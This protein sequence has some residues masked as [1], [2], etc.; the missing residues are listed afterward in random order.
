M[1]NSFKTLLTITILASTLAFA[2]CISDGDD[3][4]NT[5]MTAAYVT[6]TGDSIAGYKCFVDGGGVVLL[7]KGN[8]LRKTERAYVTMTY[9]KANLTTVDG[10]PHIKN[11]EV[12][13]GYI[14]P[15]LHPMTTSEATDKGILNP[16]SC[17]KFTAMTS[18]WGYGGYVTF[19]STFPVFV[20]STNAILPDFNIVA[21]K[22]Q[23]TENRLILR[24]LYNPHFTKTPSGYTQNTLTRANSIDISSLASTVPGNDSITVELAFEGGS[25]SCKIGRKDF[26]KPSSIFY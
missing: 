6:V 10:V 14:I 18:M 7:A 22:E 20:G 8:I 21:D 1:K 13:D 24:M 3:S 26:V 23:N 5:L 12:Y 17:A 11:A 2:S 25:K 4:N 9:T 19:L 15:V 16:D